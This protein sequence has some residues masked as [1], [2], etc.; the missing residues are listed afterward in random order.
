MVSE[1]DRPPT[2]GEQYA[3]V[4]LSFVLLVIFGGVAGLLWAI[5]G[6][7]MPVVAV[8]LVF[9]V[10]FVGSAFVFYRALCT[11]PKSLTRRQSIV[12]S[13]FL[14]FLGLVCASLSLLPGAPLKVILMV[15]GAGVGLVS[16][17]VSGIIK[18]RVRKI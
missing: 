18:P 1:L 6:L 14:V 8:T 7:H 3:G 17:G 11:S 5:G 15:L 10:L 4:V 2:K 16:Y 12:V 9:T 13:W